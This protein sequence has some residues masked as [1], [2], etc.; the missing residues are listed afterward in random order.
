MIA[1]APNSVTEMIYDEALL[2]CTFCNHDGYSDWRMPTFHE[3]I[4]TDMINGW[5]LTATDMAAS[6]PITPVRDV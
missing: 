2:Y 5:Y 3:Y 4:Y 6:W 1:L